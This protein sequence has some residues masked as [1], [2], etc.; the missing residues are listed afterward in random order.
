[1]ELDVTHLFWSYSVGRG[2][3]ATASTFCL[4][5]KGLAA[6]HPRKGKPIVRSGRKAKGRDGFFRRG[7]LVA[8]WTETPQKTICSSSAVKG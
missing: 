8:E 1:M 7:S 5:P 3:L 4:T 2:D 6:S